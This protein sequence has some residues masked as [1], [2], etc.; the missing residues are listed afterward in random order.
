MK[1]LGKDLFQPFLERSGSVLKV[2]RIYRDA[3]M[4][5]PVPYK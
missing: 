3:R 2:S 1:A 5:H 4:H